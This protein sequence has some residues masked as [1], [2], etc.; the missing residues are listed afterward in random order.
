MKVFFAPLFF[1]FVFAVAC[2]FEKP[3]LSGNL[4]SLPTKVE[5]NKEKA[6]PTPES[7]PPL[8]N[9]RIVIKK[10]KRQLE[11]FDGENLVKTYKIALGFA[12]A[13]DK[14]KQGDG[15]T[16]E[17]EFYIFTKNDRSKFYLSLGV[18]YPNAEAARRGLRDKIITKAQHD[19]IVKAIADKRA[20]PQ[21]TALGG[22]IYI[23]G[24]GSR[25]DWTWGC[26][27]LENADIKEIFDAVSVGT[28]VKIEP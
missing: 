27:A 6:A 15:K 14:E 10:E 23:H 11:F 9:P 18:S 24:G 26:A 17:G 21:N 19:Q 2:S 28:P 3:D 8:K 1:G 4:Y 5:M 7:L 12:P 22:E 25:E 16:P 13:G 20:P